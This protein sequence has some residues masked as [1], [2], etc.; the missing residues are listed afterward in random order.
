[1]QA[2]PEGLA[3]RAVPEGSAVQA[4]LEG[5]VGSVV[6]AVPEGLAVRVGQG[7]LAVQADPVVQAGPAAAPARQ[8]GPPTVLLGG[9]TSAGRE[10][11]PWAV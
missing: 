8:R 9:R 3:V 10:A 4:G 6:L 1:M 5:Q 7:E 2:V 11:R